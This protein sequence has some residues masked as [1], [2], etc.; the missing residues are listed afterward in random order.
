MKGSAL[1]LT[2][3]LLEVSHGAAAFSHV[4]DTQV[5]L[6]DEQLSYQGAKDKCVEM[7]SALVEFRSAEEWRQVRGKMNMV[8]GEKHLRPLLPSFWE[9]Q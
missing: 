2:S 3:L 6:S 4:G 8:G 1:F 9:L 5:W 7:G